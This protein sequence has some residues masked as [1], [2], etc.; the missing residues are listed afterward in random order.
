[1]TEEQIKKEHN[2]LIL[3]QMEAMTEVNFFYKYRIQILE[4]LNTM[5]AD[6]VKG[7]STE[8]LQSLSEEELSKLNVSVK[9]YTFH[10]KAGQELVTLIERMTAKSD[11]KLNEIN[12]KLELFCKRHG[13]E[14]TSASILNS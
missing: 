7:Q 4:E 9:K 8:S 10:V 11:R 3:A 6:L 14:N 13:I 5:G 1:M 2:K 12:K